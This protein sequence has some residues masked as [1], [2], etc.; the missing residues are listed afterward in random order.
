MIEKTYRLIKADGTEA[1]FRATENPDGLLISPQLT[2]M[3]IGTEITAAGFKAS[4]AQMKLENLNPALLPFILKVGDNRGNRVEAIETAAERKAKRDA[5]RKKQ[6]AFLKDRGFHW[7]KR[8]FYAS[9]PGE[10]VQRWFLLD[11]AGDAVVGFKDGGGYIAE[12]GD[13]ESVLTEIGYYG[14]AAIDKAAAAEEEASARR[15][16][17]E[18]I[19]TF[20][21]QP[22]LEVPET[23]VEIDQPVIHIEYYLPRRQFQIIEGDALWIKVHNTSDGDDWSQNN[24]DFGIARR[25]PF[26]SQITEY[27]RKLAT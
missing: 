17:R 4:D 20:F 14:Q 7:E 18:A 24:C 6:N 1:I 13:V 27:L 2:P 15:Q 11:P 22:A 19:D 25:Y 8:S 3:A 21:R 10:M 23:D 5:E 16:M 12:F 26:D 9:D